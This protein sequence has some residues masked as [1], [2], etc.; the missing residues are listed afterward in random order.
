MLKSAAF[1][2]LLILSGCHRK[3]ASVAKPHGLSLPDLVTA[4]GAPLFATEQLYTEIVRTGDVWQV[5]DRGK[6]L[7]EQRIDDEGVGVFKQA[8]E[9]VRSRKGEGRILLAAGGKVAFGEIRS[10]IRAAAKAGFWRIEFLVKSSTK[11]GICSLRLDLPTMDGKGNPWPRE[12]LQFQVRSDGSIH[13]GEGFGRKTLESSS[14]TSRLD[15]YL[16]SVEQNARHT[17]STPEVQVYADSE[18]PFQRVID[19]L[20]G[21]Q[22]HGISEVYFI[23]PAA[24]DREPDPRAKPRSPRSSQ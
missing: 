20:A 9:R 16:K 10:A 24:Y 18:A 17:K 21:L 4:E 19:V 7:G 13:E 22:V 3:V 14:G 5:Y 1:A 8:H 6:S 2:F 11:T 15:A 23:D 12:P